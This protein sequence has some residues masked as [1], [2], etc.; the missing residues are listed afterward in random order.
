MN[1]LAIDT[2]MQ[3]CSVAVLQKKA[4]GQ[5]CLS[6]CYEERA[7]GHAERLMGMIDEVLTKADMTIRQVDQFAVCRGPG[8][9]TGVRI[10]IATARGL[11]LAC[12]RPLRG[13]GTLEVL[14]ARVV[15]EQAEQTEQAEQVNPGQS[16]LERHLGI[17]VDARRGEIYWQLFDQNGQAQS[18]P[19][20]QNPQIT[21]ELIQHQ[22]HPLHLAGSGAELIAEHLKP[23]TGDF[24]FSHPQLQPDAARLATLVANTPDVGNQPAQS[25]SPLYLRPAD[26]KTQSGYA[27]ERQ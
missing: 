12:A 5:V 10:G 4:K 7:R 2:S 1:I 25:A 17:A 22:R 15:H 8:T 9:F 23:D 14:A 19:L 3:A 11:A 24:S 18:E 16:V 26:A 6:A 13:I 20:A 21:A 27:I